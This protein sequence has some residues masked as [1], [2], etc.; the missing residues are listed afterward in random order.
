MKVDETNAK[1][2]RY[3]VDRDGPSGFFY[4]SVQSYASP[5]VR[6]VAETAEAAPRETVVSMVLLIAS[7]V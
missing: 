5:P 4:P 2:P 6:E 1:L 3:V 7:L